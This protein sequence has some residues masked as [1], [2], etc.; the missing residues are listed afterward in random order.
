MHGKVS[1]AFFGSPI[2]FNEEGSKLFGQTVNARVVNVDLDPVAQLPCAN[3]ANGWPRC[4]GD[5]FRSIVKT[6]KGR[7]FYSKPP[8]LY[9]VTT[10]MQEGIWSCSF[11]YRSSFVC[12][13]CQISMAEYSTA[14]Y[15][16]ITSNWGQINIDLERREFKMIIHIPQAVRMVASHNTLYECRLSLFCTDD[17]KAQW[18]CGPHYQNKPFI[19]TIPIRS[20]IR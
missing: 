11:S 10:K 15:L 6:G 16:D 7:D 12:L 18:N 19:F 20:P 4:G 2:A 5:I 17:R 9:E 8:A 3:L 14:E 1:G 13:R